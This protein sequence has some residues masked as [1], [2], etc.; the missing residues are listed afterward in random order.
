MS[1]IFNL[2]SINVR[3]LRNPVKRAT[4]FSHLSSICF[5]VC[6]LQVHLKDQNYV[7]RFTREWVQGESRWSVG[8]VHSTGV[9]VLCGNRELKIVGRFSAVHGR[10]LVVDIDWRGKCFRF[11]NV[12]APPT[13]KERREMLN[14]L[15]AIF[16][17]N[18]QVFMGGDFNVSYDRGNLG[19]HLV[20]SLIEK[21]NLVDSYRVAHADNPGFTWG[22][23][24]GARNRIDYMFVPRGLG[25]SSARITPVF[26]SD[27]SCLS[28]TVE[29]K[30]IEFGTGYSKINNDI[31]HDKTFDTR[32]RYLRAV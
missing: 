6:F 12:Y 23:S 25:V 4:V 31:L 7:E 1:S 11:I 10:V 15:D 2:A 9:G 17:T 22:N 32:F 30:T 18:R 19:G 3:G 29:L 26:Y 24:R 27:H 8:G 21:Y 13:P 5:S 16:M 14:D 28:V 20:K